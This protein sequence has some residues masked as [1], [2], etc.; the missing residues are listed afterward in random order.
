MALTVGEVKEISISLTVCGAAGERTR[1][2][3]ASSFIS[4]DE[5]G[6]GA[7]AFHRGQ[8]PR[9]HRCH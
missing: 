1:L 7:A 6:R 2:G 9:S 4:R 8:I 5:V 3:I